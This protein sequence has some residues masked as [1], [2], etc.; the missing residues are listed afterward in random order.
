M[1]GIFTFFLFNIFLFCCSEITLG[2]I[3]ARQ[4]FETSPATPELTYT[5]SG[6]TI[7]SGTRMGGRPSP[8]PQY[9][10]G[11]RSI[12]GNN[13]TATLTFASVDTRTYTNITATFRLASI[14]TTTGN[15]AE[16]GDIVTV[17]VSPDGGSN[18]YNQ[19]LVTGNNN[20]CWGFPDG[21]AVASRP[22]ATSTATTFSPG[23]AN[24]TSMADGYGTVTVTNLPAV[25]NLRLRI[26]LL[27]N[28]AAEI[29]LIDDVTITGDQNAPAL[30][31][32][33]VAVTG[34]NYNAGNGPSTVQSTALTGRKLSPASDSVMITAPA[35]FQIALGA[36][37]PFTSSSFKIPYSGDTLPPVNIYVRL[38]AGLTAGT[39]ADSVRISG[40]GA[41]TALAVSGQVYPTACSDLF[42]SEYVEGS[43]NNKYIELYNPTSS[44]ITLRDATRSYYR[45]AQYNNGSSTATSYLF[46]VNAS[47]APYGVYVVAHPSA[48][49]PLQSGPDHTVSITFNGN[50]VVALQKTTDG[51]TYNSI[52]VLGEIGV[53][54]GS[55][56]TAG[57]ITTVDKTLV[58]K[59]TVVLGRTSETGF[60]GL[61]TEWE[62]HPIDEMHY[63][64]AHVSQ[65]AT[66][67]IIYIANTIPATTYCPGQSF[68]VDFTT[69]GTF[70]AGNTFTL[71]LSNQHGYFSS[72]AAIGTLNLAGTNVSGT[73]AATIPPAAV[74][75]TNY[76]LRILASAPGS[77][78]VIGTQHLTVYSS[79]PNNVTNPSASNG[80]QMTP[81]SWS[82]PTAGCWE[83]VMVVL[84]TTAGLTF[85]PSGNGSTYTANPVYAGTG[86]QVV[87][88]G[89]GTNVDIS[90]LT[91][92]T[93]YYYE[94][95]TRFGNNWSSG[96]ELAHLTDIY[97]YPQTVQACDE[98]IS[99][100][101]IGT[102]DHST[103]EGC[104]YNGYNWHANQTTDLELGQTYE[105]NIQVGIV[106]DGPD[107]SYN[108]N[109]IKVW[110][111]W[112]RDG[113]FSNNASERVVNILNNGA[114]GSYNITVPATAGTGPVRMRV[115]VLYDGTTNDLP[116]KKNHTYGETED[117]TL[118]IV[119]P[120]T[121]VT[122]NFSFYPTSGSA[123]TEVRITKVTSAST[124]N[125]STVTGVKF[126][127][128]NATSFTIVDDNT[129]FAI[130]PEGAGTGRITLEDNSPCKRSST[131]NF[132]FEKKNAACA[133]YT[134][135]FISEVYDP[136]SGN[137]HYIELFNGTTD[138]I[139]LSAPDNYALR[140]LNKSSYGDASPSTSTINI[141]GT[142][143]P[144]ET[145]VYYAGA[146]GGLAT[147]TQAS[148]GSG[149]NRY[150]DIVLVKN[151][152]IIDICTATSTEPFGYQ[153]R[154]DIAAPSTTFNV[155]EWTVTAPL[156]TS[157]I[158]LF[159]ALKPLS[160]TA[161]PV[162][163]I[164]C[165]VNMQI[166]A[167]GA[168]TLTYQWYYNYNRVNQTG[169][170]AL[171]D[172][173]SQFT[174]ATVSGAASDQLLITGDLGALSN[175]Q[176][177]CVVT[178]GSCIESSD[179]AQFIAKPEIYF[180]SKAPGNWRAAAT[181]EMSP[182]GTP[183]SWVDACTFPWDTNSVSVTILNEHQITIV[184]IAANTPDVQIDQLAID[185]GGILQIEPNAEL[186]I[187]NDTGTDL[188]VEGTLYDQSNGTA[189]GLSFLNDATWLLGNQ[190][191][192]I[193]TGT[194]PASV[195]RNNYEGGIANIPV[196][197]HWIY[198]KETAINPAT[199]S[200]N[201][202]YPNL[203][204][205]NIHSSGTFEFSG[206]NGF[207]TVKG[208]M[209]L[210]GIFSTLVLDTNTN[211]TPFRISGDL[212]INNNN[213]FRNAGSNYIGTG[214]EVGGNIVNNGTLDMNTDNIGL[215]RMNGT[216][217][218][219]ISGTGVFDIWNFEMAKSP[220]TKVQLATNLEIKNQLTFTGGIIQ[221]DT[222]EIYISNGDVL[223]AITGHDVPNG[224][225]I[226][227][228]DRYV[229]GKLR[230][231]ITESNT[232]V[233]PVGDVETGLGYNPSR[234]IIRAIPIGTPTAMGEFIAAWPG[235]INTFRDITCAGNYKF[236]E[237]T[238][239][240]NQG[241]WKYDGSTFANY[242]I[243]IHPN[244]R[245]LNIRPNES[246]PIG[247]TNTYRALKES[248]DRAGGLWSPDAATAGDPCIVSPNYY[249]IIGAGYSG[250][251]I[252]A[253]GGGDG[254][255][256]ALP[257]SLLYFNTGCEDKAV[258]VLW[259][260]ASELNTDYF[261]IERSTDG[262]NY[263]AVGSVEAAGN[264]TQKR[265]YQ[266]LDKAPLAGSYYR[267]VE[268]DLDGSVYYHGIREISCG[269]HND[270]NP[271]IYYTPA[272]GIIS[273]LEATGKIPEA[274]HVFDASGR[275]ISNNVLRYSSNRYILPEALYWPKGV[276]IVSI[277]FADEIVSEK[278]VVY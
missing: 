276:Y 31:V 239:L 53:D 134:D 164:G 273:I 157:N 265:E 205:E 20:T 62:M 42:I 270:H 191:T 252:F 8:T 29:W 34:L 95:Y 222:N 141:T 4:D 259:A 73:I 178:N 64:G 170:I 253:P 50:D 12:G 35:D 76:L 237:Y 200:I 247:H 208:N 192:V 186:Y 97:C 219:T 235:T 36:S 221:T 154:N 7:Y 175:Y 196:T 61:G 146:N 135:L 39:Y 204:F 152:N 278:V 234:L 240:T 19:I 110:I 40:G 5:N 220:Q 79:T 71:Q 241:Y 263:T 33:P 137:N 174:T 171:T 159:N 96:I 251:S 9:V 116:C 176:F 136:P 197:A 117:Y 185:S 26:T 155:S 121:P 181:W 211:A 165:E 210:R 103:P 246:T 92:G 37:G 59:P 150:D 245:N 89:T 66:P 160:I 51:S 47:I 48:T 217:L 87:Y 113:T 74:A 38:A 215:I 21:L 144:G 32:L 238:G 249:E 149:F 264:S 91:N 168:G 17:S 6:G 183:G 233:F 127:N 254:N 58:R 99:R 68:T 142:I 120:C 268:T 131:G 231:R 180:R 129:I 269:G 41:Y 145:R 14:S 198:R 258:K 201:M 65:C 188:V 212:V 2:A 126:N 226:Y 88:K 140:V 22:Y 266:F 11:N 25:E 75:G 63:L 227:A 256:T 114:S 275:L 163:N 130:V 86:N 98:Y 179:A 56:W 112:N 138:I 193:K 60:P 158:S 101:Q 24:A 214:I 182:D 228:D 271:A 108:N 44:T 85:N 124:G 125:F 30:S 139:D 93:I 57:G 257:I 277:V 173:T 49:L 162:D 94:I 199:T 248:N 3:I 119:E 82:N 118:N 70:P 109:D 67:N 243:F 78:G 81:L 128:I 107:I 105:L 224:T 261:T 27:N 43:S 232:Y 236:I 161:Q 115:Q 260:T 83:E 229:I 209:I 90:G 166:T 23:Y 187:N 122:S 156:N 274:I 223:N 202:F 177:Y 143:P 10:S 216:G 28:A 133:I 55:A 45:L 207:T 172:G 206:V 242:D 151:G 195:Y 18:W 190:G 250:F 80:D 100:V 123:G 147:G 102:I 1:K 148:T 167:I 77:D 213:V 106:G 54:P 15:G 272:E 169:W 244:I 104:G 72:P 230:R 111:D 46:P 13:S 184:E 84:T 262:I 52:D 132:T 225:G 255:T 267:L 153:R 69:T 16:T 203:Y 189:N 218:Q 194:S